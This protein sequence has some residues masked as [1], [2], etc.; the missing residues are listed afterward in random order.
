MRSELCL[1]G[2]ALA[3]MSLPAFAADQ[4]KDVR[5]GTCEDA[6]K[7]VDYF[8]RENPRDTMVGIGTACTNAKKNLKAACEG[9]VEPDRKYEFKDSK[10]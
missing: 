4:P 7:Q 9:I 3:V 10:K 5:A 1:A 6:K 2:F 8:C